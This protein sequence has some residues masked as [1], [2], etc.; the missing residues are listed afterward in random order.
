MEFKNMKTIAISIEGFQHGERAYW[1][2]SSQGKFDD[3]ALSRTFVFQPLGMKFLNAVKE[4][5]AGTAEICTKYH[6]TKESLHTKFS[7][8]KIN[9]HQEANDIKKLKYCLNFKLLNAEQEAAMF[10]FYV[11]VYNKYLYERKISN[12]VQPF[13]VHEEEF[14]H[15]EENC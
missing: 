9:I 2:R 8:F 6:E 11:R 3:T 15:M 13:A 5:M 14:V 1:V 7:H 10:A 12:T 4:H